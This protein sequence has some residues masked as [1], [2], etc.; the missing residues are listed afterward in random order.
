MLL[1]RFFQHV[2]EWVVL[3]DGYHPLSQSYS[4]AHSRSVYDMYMHK[5]A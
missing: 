5:F 2:T 1:H 3:F 4:T